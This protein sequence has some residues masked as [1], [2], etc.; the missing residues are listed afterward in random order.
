MALEIPKTCV[1][2]S[3]ALGS[4]GSHRVLFSAKALKTRP[5]FLGFSIGSSK[6]DNSVD[7]EWL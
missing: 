5:F 3:K 4:R 7:C 2:R 6:F 1:F